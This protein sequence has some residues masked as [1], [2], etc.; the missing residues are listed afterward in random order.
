[1]VGGRHRDA[2]TYLLVDVFAIARRSEQVEMTL[3]LCRQLIDQPADALADPRGQ[4]TPEVAC[5]PLEPRRD[6]QDLFQ[7]RA[8]AFAFAA[9]DMALCLCVQRFTPVPTAV[10]R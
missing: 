4:I 7:R 9:F 1:V 3:L 10:A 2:L 5:G 8:V 6:L